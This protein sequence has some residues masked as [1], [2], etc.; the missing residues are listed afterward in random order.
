MW[1]GRL[2]SIAD[3]KE[4]KQRRNLYTYSHKTFSVYKKHE[5]QSRSGLA[6][7]FLFHQFIGFPVNSL[8]KSTSSFL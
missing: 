3:L 7:G 8:I 6:F 5:D 1:M 4:L 2:N